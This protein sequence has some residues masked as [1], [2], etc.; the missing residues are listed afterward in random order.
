METQ[1]KPLKL[2]IPAN[3]KHSKAALTL[4]NSEECQIEGTN[5]FDFLESK[6]KEEKWEVRIDGSAYLGN[7]NQND[8]AEG[9]GAMIDIRGNLLL[10]KYF[11][12]NFVGGSIVTPSGCLYTPV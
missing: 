12:D 5:I 4:L 8:E 10:G 1:Q 6:Q 2:C 9:I 7:T 11:K 3:I